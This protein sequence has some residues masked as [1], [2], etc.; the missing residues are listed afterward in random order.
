MYFSNEVRHKH[1][2]ILFFNIRL[3]NIL[4]TWKNSGTTKMNYTN[5]IDTGHYSETS[6]QTSYSKDRSNLDDRHLSNTLLAN[7]KMFIYYCVS[8]SAQ[9]VCPD[10]PLVHPG[11][12]PL[13]N[14]LLWYCTYSPNPDVD[15]YFISLLETSILI[16]IL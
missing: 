4:L 11:K 5:I 15:K 1:V 13:E 3:T 2:L 14:L 6:E 7:L 8:S 12:I 9:C 16:I 10:V